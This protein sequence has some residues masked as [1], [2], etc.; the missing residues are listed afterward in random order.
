MTVL[1]SSPRSEV[2]AQPAKRVTWTMTLPLIALAIALFGVGFHRE[3]VIAFD[4]WIGTTA[5]NYCLLILPIVAYLLWER[6]TVIAGC[7]PDPAW[8]PLILLVPLSAGWLAAAL[9]DINEGRQL[10]MVAMFEV[11]LLAALGQRLY[12]QLLAPLLF[13]FFLVP[14]GAFLIAWLQSVTAEMAVAGLRLLRIP[15]FSDGYLI[16]IPEGS[17]AIAEAC[18][19]LRFLASATVFSCL[20]AVVMY[21]GW[22]RRASYVALSIPTAILA[23]GMRAFGII[24]LAHLLGSATAA[25]ADHILY[26]Y[27]FFSLIIALLIGIG[28]LM[29]ERNPAPPPSTL[30]SASGS[31]RRNAL[32]VP[33]AALLALTGPAYAVWLDGGVPREPLPAIAGPTVHAPWRTLAATLPEWRPVV[34]GADREFLAAFEAPGSA[35]VTRYVALYR[36]HATGNYLTRADNRLADDVNWH[37]VHQG[38][39]TASFAGKKETVTVTELERGPYRRLV[40]SF[41]AVDGR[42]AA[43]LLEAKL[44]QVRAVL[45]EK[46]P[47]GAFVAVTASVDGPIDGAARQLDRFMAAS[48][49]FPRYLE[50]L[51][52]SLDGGS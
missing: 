24:L 50:A 40:W 19:G 7:S 27:L 8:W 49:P 21:R 31:R 46:N 29:A 26:G 32:A 10:L 34:Q 23:N 39:G 47:I 12:R 33:L 5:Y 42:I 37:V 36:L 38:R 16:D 3:A 28:M 44:L 4:T 11:V 20:F 9:L 17:F 25:E 18:A 1:P 13:L 14:A 52:R 45:R 15:V 22:W 48:E 41:Y 43:S 6:R 2:V 35:G 51:R 30:P